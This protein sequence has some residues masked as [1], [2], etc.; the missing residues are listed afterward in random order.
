MTVTVLSDIHTEFWTKQAVD[1]ASGDV[2]ILAGDIGQVCSLGT[3]DGKQYE[4]FLNKCSERYNK[5]FYVL[6]NHEYYDGDLFD[7]PKKLKDHVTQYKNMTVLD[8][9]SEYYNGVHYVGGTMWT[10][11][12]N[13]DP[14]VM[15]DAQS[16]M[17]DYSVIRVAQQPLTPHHILLKHRETI[18]WFSQALQT[19][20]GP[21]VMVTH[22]APSKQSIHGR[23]VGGS[24]TDAYYSDLE[25]MMLRYKNI[26]NWCHGHVHVSNNYYVEQ[27]NV[28][29][30]PYGYDKYETNLGFSTTNQFIPSHNKC[31]SLAS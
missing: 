10:D 29:S 2:L 19:L 15:M 4:K 28:I 16:F 30:N 18:G 13:A 22:H 21:V 20:R 11:F 27:C 3:R 9:N 7:T 17:T 5:V 12:K 25:P 6:G 14:L 26:V 31:L 24:L 8:T 1:P 23:Y